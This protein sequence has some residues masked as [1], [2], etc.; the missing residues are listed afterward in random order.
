MTQISRKVEKEGFHLSATSAAFKLTGIA[1]FSLGPRNSTVHQKFLF[2]FLSL[3]PFSLN[4]CFV[5]DGMFFPLL[6]LFLLSA[7]KSICFLLLLLLYR[8]RVFTWAGTVLEP[9]YTYVLHN[10]QPKG[11]KSS[12]KNIFSH[13]FGYFWYFCPMKLA[14]IS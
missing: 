13:F 14:F 11:K 1:S 10:I 4:H 2:L 3:L 7:W 9:K 12:S 5:C 6:K 8:R